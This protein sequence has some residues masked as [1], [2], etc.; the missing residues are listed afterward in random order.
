MA[1]PLNAYVKEQYRAD[2]VRTGS[3][4]GL[5]FAVKDVF[6][7]EGHANA[8]GNPGW[9]RTHSTRNAPK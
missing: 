4:S 9:K 6:G 2:P 8:A 7:L 3:L 5:T 1:R